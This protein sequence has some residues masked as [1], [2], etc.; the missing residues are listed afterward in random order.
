MKRV[1]EINAELAKLNE[2]RDGLAA[3]LQDVGFKG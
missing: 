1:A 3:Q 2:E